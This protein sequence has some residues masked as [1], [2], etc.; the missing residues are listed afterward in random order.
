MSGSREH[1]CGR[2]CAPDGTAWRVR[3]VQIGLRSTLAALPA[4]SL[5]IAGPLAAR[6]DGAA[7][8]SADGSSGPGTRSAVVLEA[9]TILVA[10]RSLRDPNF[11][12]SVVVLIAYAEDGAAGLVVNRRT[13]LTLDRALPRFPGPKGPPALAFLGGPVDVSRTWALLRLS[14]ERRDAP[15][16]MDD[17]YLL[18]SRESLTGALASGAGPDRFRVYLGYAG[19]GAGQLEREVR[20]GA[21]RVRAPEPDVVF[22]ASPDTLWRRQITLTEALL[23]RAD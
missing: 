10:A 13:A 11:A 18:N 8:R 9:G 19:W 17:V 20:A 6:P 22:D 7:A 4:L 5:L 15:R 16:I 12:E 2:R 3:Q 23:A 14:A 1:T 21:W